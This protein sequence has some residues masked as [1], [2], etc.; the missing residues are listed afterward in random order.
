MQNLAAWVTQSGG[1]LMLTGGTD[2]YGPGGYYKSPLEP[3]LPV[4]M[5]L[6]REHRK[7]QL[8]IVVALDRSGSMA[9]PTP[10]GRAKIE[11]A[12]LATAEVLNMLGPAD[13]FGCLAVDTVPH[14]IV[15]F[16]HVTDKEAMRQ[17][18][19]RIDSA[20]GGI[21]IYEALVAASKM[22]LSAQAGTRHIILFSDASDAEQS[23]G[24][25]TI[26]D[27]C[28]KAGITVS[29]V[30][31]GT[32]RDCDANLLKDIAKRGG[33]QCM[34][35]NVAQELPRI[36]AQDTFMI[37][38]SAFLEE[39][40]RVHSTG[41]LTSITQQPLG[42]FPRIGGYNL[43]YLRPEANLALVSVDE[44]QA[45][46]LTSWQAGLGRV[47]CYAGEADGK[48][49][50]PIARWKNVG[51]FFTSLA[52]WTAGKSQG[53]GKDIVATQELR[54]GVC[55]VQLHL[56]PAREATPLARLPEL[57]TLAAR[58]GEI[59]VPRTT[60]M[61]WSSADTLLAEVPLAGSETILTTVDAARLGQVTL[62]PMCLPYSP[63]YQ[64]PKPGQGIDAL[65][66][67]GKID[68]RL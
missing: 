49:T 21:Y 68:R 58:P 62:A 52:R 44:Y 60:R 7:L 45:P 12:D 1:G 55:R 20:G 51:D 32:E 18:I 30:G 35:T 25:E 61:N 41:G 24:Y 38:R 28:R 53:L 23:P 4:S 42:K 66:L 47:L 16:G 46:L 9:I 27:A 6:R 8:A 31:L 48:Y 34:F 19:L 36:F 13:Q 10:D 37:A 11:L 40:V 54:G 63:E 22:I 56:D 14:E 33:G 5:E 64:P 3:I 59:A 15:P 50:G 57:T 65:E 39:P 26:V 2:S 67:P 17:K 29:V 43:C